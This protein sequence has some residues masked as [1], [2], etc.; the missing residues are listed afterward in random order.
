MCKICESIC[1]QIEGTFGHSVDPIKLM[2]LIES[3]PLEDNK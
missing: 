1:K 3:S 2:E